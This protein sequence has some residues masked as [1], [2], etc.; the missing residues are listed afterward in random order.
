MSEIRFADVAE[1]VKAT[2]AA[3]CLALDDG[4]ADDVAATFCPDGTAD[5]PGLGTHT[6][7]DALRAAYERVAPRIPQRHLVLNTVVTEWTP[8]TAHAVS[9]LVFLLR[10]D[11]WAVQM[12]GRY[13]DDLRCIDGDWRF[14]LRRAEFVA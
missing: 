9:D 7:H 5:I 8:V 6:G 11:T 10:R 12:V 2:I 4:R 13:H 1:G 14:A 3:Y